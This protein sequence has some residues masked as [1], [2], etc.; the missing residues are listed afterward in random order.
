MNE[1]PETAK[2]FSWK[3]PL[4]R[5]LA[6]AVIIAGLYLGAANPHF[7]FMEGASAIKI[8]HARAIL[9][10]QG[11]TDIGRIGTPPEIVRPPGF[12]LFMAGVFAL[13]GENLLIL[14]ILN[15]LFAPAGFMV[16]F[17]LLQRRFPSPWTAIVIASAGYLFPFFLGMAR[18][19]EAEFLFCLL[20]FAA[21]YVFER[22]YDNGLERKTWLIIF[23]LLVCLSSL[24]RSVGFILVPAALPVLGFMSN[25][26]GKRR[27]A[28]A[29]TIV[30]AWA[31]IGGG[32]MVRNQVVPPPGEMTYVDKLLADEPVDSIYWLLED[33]RTPLLG[34][35][36]RASLVDVIARAG[37]NCG[38]YFRKLLESAGE[39]GAISP[40]VLL[41]GLLPVLLMAFG[42]AFELVKRRRLM[43][44]VTAV[45]LAV[46]L[47][48]P[49]QDTRF[50]VPVF[51]LLLYY[52]AAGVHLVFRAFTPSAKDFRKPAL[53][54]TVVIISV[55]AAVY[56]YRD[57]R[58]LVNDKGAS[59]RVVLQRN[60]HFQITATS[61]G[62]RHSLLLL[63]WLRRNSERGE[64]I[65]YHSYA[66]CALIT[67]RQCSGIPIGRPARVIRYVREKNVDRVVIDDEWKHGHGY[68]AVYTEKTLKPTCRAYADYFKPVKTL[69]GTDA[70]VLK[71]VERK[72]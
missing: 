33:Q 8:L 63:D 58:L 20:F 36:G 52:L 4:F 10:G 49:Y 50:L 57:L 14:K 25:A 9:S 21:L 40:A 38:F 62:T 23:A 6:F 53:V 11:Y 18:Y 61:A 56:A 32:W 46:I 43:E 68:M 66:P 41:A 39:K 28:W 17:L 54:A 16:L 55:L 7:R 45:Y 65:M 48:W 47:F 51:P 42:L 22:A 29:V 34:K 35:P 24:V 26:S 37:P 12:P 1:K 31:L 13:C 72:E 15:N 60:E 3:H 67:G 44:A 2:G 71:V 5:A 19:L 69:P 59:D 30:L 27:L 64:V 70:R